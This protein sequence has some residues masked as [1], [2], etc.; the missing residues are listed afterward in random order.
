MSIDETEK[1]WYFI[2][3]NRYLVINENG[4]YTLTNYFYACHEKKVGY[5]ENLPYICMNR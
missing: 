3:I 5:F 2:H 4:I 1:S